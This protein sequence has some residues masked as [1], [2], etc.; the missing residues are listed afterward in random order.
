MDRGSSEEREVDAG[1]RLTVRGNQPFRLDQGRLRDDCA[2]LLGCL[3]A[4][5]HEIRNPKSK[6][7]NQPEN[8]KSQA[9]NPKSGSA[10]WDLF[11]IS[12][13]GFRISPTGLLAGPEGGTGRAGA[14]FVDRPSHGDDIVLGGCNDTAIVSQPLRS[15]VE[16]TTESALAVQINARHADFFD[17]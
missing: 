7:R 8:L 16:G 14:L 10:L 3:R 5:H 13:F 17:S 12:D 15:V 9:R 4:W 2:M 11:R 1:Q 6:I